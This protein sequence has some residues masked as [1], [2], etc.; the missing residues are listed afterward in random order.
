MTPRLRNRLVE[1]VEVAPA[2]CVVCRKL[3]PGGESA[4]GWT[5]LA[6][7]TPV[8]AMTCSPACAAVAV[9]RWERTGR[10]DTADMR[11]DRGG[12]R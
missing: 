10:V 5:Y 1:D 4:A 7:S 2:G 12:R 6:N 3:H 8:G 9:K 11:V